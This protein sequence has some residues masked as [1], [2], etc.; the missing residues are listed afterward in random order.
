MLCDKNKILFYL[1]FLFLTWFWYLRGCGTLRRWWLAGEVGLIR[2]QTNLAWAC[3][4]LSGDCNVNDPSTS[5]G[6]ICHLPH[7]A[8]LKCL[9]PWSNTALLPRAALV[10]MMREWLTVWMYLY[11][12]HA[13]HVICACVRAC[14]RMCLCGL[15]ASNRQNG[16]H[17]TEIIYEFW[18][19]VWKP[20]CCWVQ[21]LPRPQSWALDSCFFTISFVL[22]ILVSL[23]IQFLLCM[24]E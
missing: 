8:G 14:V 15:F 5:P 22:V 20:K 7:C 21:C 11:Y 10:S 1:A 9:K 23:N 19:M 24:D 16:Y 13:F 17:T 2:S 4:L 3:F 18:R 12:T 6:S